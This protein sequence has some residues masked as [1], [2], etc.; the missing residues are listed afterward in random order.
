LPNYRCPKCGKI[1]YL[2]MT[3][4]K[5]RKKGTFSYRFRMI[6]VSKGK[7]TECFLTAYNPARGN[8]GS[9]KP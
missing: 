6:H 3:E 8:N 4:V 9:R 5:D 2:V 1:G 7:R